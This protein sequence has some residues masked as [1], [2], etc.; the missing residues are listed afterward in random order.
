MI[1]NLQSKTFDFGTKAETL[2][3]LQQFVTT[4]RIP[5]VCFFSKKDWERSRSSIIKEID[6]NFKNHLVAVRS[7]ALVEDSDKNSM[8]GAFLTKL[9]IPVNDN[10]HL[11]LAI[12]AVYDAMT[13]NQGDQILV[14]PMINNVSLSGV[15]MTFDMVN[16]APYYCIDYDDETGLTNGITSGCGVHKSL[17]IYRHVNSTLIKSPRILAIFKMAKELEQI[18]QC[19]ALDI[20]FGMDEDGILYLLQVR[21]ISLARNWHPVTEKRIARQL[22]HVEEFI[23]NASLPKDGILGARTILAIMPDWNPAEIIGTT[24]RPLALSLYRELITKQ[25]WHKSR[26]QMGYKKMYDAELMVVINNHCYIDVRNSFNSFLPYDLPDEIG[27]KLINSWLERLENFPEYHDKIEFE[28]VPTCIDF[29]FKDDFESR[30]PEVLNPLELEKYYNS[31]LNLT[32]KCL[33]SKG[34]TLYAALHDAQVLNDLTLP[35]LD[36]NK[37]YSNLL[38]AGYLIK[39]CKQLGTLPFAVAARHAF[40]AEAI[41]RSAVRCKALTENRLLEFK[42]SIKTITGIM[43]EDYQNV[44][45]G[46]LKRDDFLKKYGHLRPGTYEITSLRYDE[47]DDLFTEIEQDNFTSNKIKFELSNNEYCELEKLLALHNLD[48]LNPQELL[49]YARDAI[50]GREYIK[51]VFTK[52]LSNALSHIVN[53]GISYGLSR[54]DLSY[55]YWENIYNGLSN[56]VIDDVDRY[57]LTLADDARRSMHATCGFRLAHI[58]SKP[59]DIHIATLNRS[60]PNF[61]GNDYVVGKII[62]LKPNTPTNINIK[63]CIVCIENADPGFDWIFTKGP[64]ALVTCFGGANSHMAVRCAELG[65]PAAI[66]C[67]DQIYYRIVSTKQIELNCQEKFLRP[68]YVK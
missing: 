3:N 31:L 55:L 15:I 29:C 63:N 5:K 16:G 67:G 34:N 37:G 52:N 65:L 33:T 23:F 68:I 42:R 6:E 13:Q 61:V 25:I 7:S 35:P 46:I 27:E 26:Y 58:I 22:K 49:D 53:W 47:R 40:I 38:R 66:G 10:H 44:Y 50:S 45:K 59:R 28:I 4:A 20:E 9:N 57:Y 36:A 32:R 54:D 56:P 11:S 60:V 18:C 51:F 62:E 1:N 64:K 39:Q 14:Q 48:V 41:L 19:A 17:Y 43:L 2:Q 21:R 12:D 30:Y 8:A 24:P